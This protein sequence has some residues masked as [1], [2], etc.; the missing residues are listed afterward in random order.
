MELDGREIGEEL[1]DL[2]S[3][4]EPLSH[5]IARGERSDVLAPEPHR[6]FARLDDAGEEVD[7]RRLAGAIGT[8]QRLSRARRKFQRDVVGGDEAA[9]P[10]RQAAR[11]ENGGAHA[12]PPS[13]D[14]FGKIVR[15]ARE[16]SAAT[17]SRPIS[18]SATSNAP[19]Q[20][21]QYSGV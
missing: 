3:A 9:E 20:N 16:M 21:S 8:D 17:R 12:T 2:K 1:V 5:S 15:T 18:T 4:R 6:A 11:L 7:Q 19:I 14:A 13:F 10:A